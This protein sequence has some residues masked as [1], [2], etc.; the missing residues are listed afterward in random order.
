ME[1]LL[2]AANKRGGIPDE[3]L[4]TKDEYARFLRDIWLSHEFA[5]QHVTVEVA[6]EDERFNLT[7]N[8][9]AKKILPDQIVNVLVD[10]WV[11]KEYTITYKNVPVVLQADKPDQDNWSK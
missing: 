6:N 3:F 11:K 5:H 4:L 8:V 9:K 10:K 1:D 7:N 2:E